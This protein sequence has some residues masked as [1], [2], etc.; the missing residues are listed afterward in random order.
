LKTPE[1]KLWASTFTGPSIDFQWFGRFVVTTV[2]GLEMVAVQV[3]RGAVKQ[4]TSDFEDLVVTMSGRPLRGR[5]S[6]LYAGANGTRVAVGVRSFRHL[7]SNGN[8]EFVMVESPSIS[9][10]IHASPAATEF[11]KD[12]EKQLE[13]RHL[14]WIHLESPSTA[15]FTGILPQLWGLEART[16]EVDAMLVAPSQRELKGHATHPEPEVARSC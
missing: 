1:L 11:P 4:N 16:P 13:F 5:G 10:M 7:A 8:L 12:A 9:F 2:E 14:D 6:Q 15:N 3:R